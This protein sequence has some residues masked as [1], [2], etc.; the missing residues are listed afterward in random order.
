MKV[1]IISIAVLLLVAIGSVTFAQ[2]RNQRG[3]TNE[4]GAQ[5]GMHNN[6]PMMKQGAQR[7][8]GNGIVGEIENLNKTAKTFDIEAKNNATITVTINEDTIIVEEDDLEDLYD[9]TESRGRQRD[10]RNDLDTE[11]MT[12]A[13]VRKALFDANEERIAEMEKAIE[14]IAIDFSELEEGDKVSVQMSPSGDNVARLI[15]IE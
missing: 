9:N 10:L 12:D 6:A 15:I 8:G 13:E 4:R 1:K 7:M 11:G 3:G 5:G 14:A 2:A